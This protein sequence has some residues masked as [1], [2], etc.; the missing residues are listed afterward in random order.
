MLMFFRGSFFAKYYTMKIGVIIPD[1]N[2][3]PLFLKNCLRLLSE[4]TKKDFL[5]V[6]LVND[7]FGGDE[8]VPDITKRYRLGYDKLRG[9]GLDCI[10]LMENDDWYA[11]DYIETMVAKWEEH[12]RPDLFGTNYTIYYHIKLFSYFTMYHETRSSAMSTLIKPDLDFHWCADNETYTDIHLWNTIQNRKVFKPEK[13]I[14][15]GI[16]HGDG[17]C[18][19]RSHVDRLERYSPPNGFEDKSADYLWATV[20]S[21]SFYFYNNYFKK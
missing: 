19:G 1:R 6:V 18:G 12:G 15:L 11:K 13:I 17:L 5:Y 9:K 7:D 3:R 14:C 20:D 2:D 8:N 4:Q 16:K 21:K 10:L